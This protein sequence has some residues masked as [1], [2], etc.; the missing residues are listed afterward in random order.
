MVDRVAELVSEGQAATNQIVRLEMLVGCLDEREF[1]RNER[2]FATLAELPIR[3]STWDNAAKLGFLLRRKGITA[4]IP[5]LM[6]ATSAIE[7][8]M[9]LIHADKDFNAMVPFCELRVESYADAAI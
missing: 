1:S 3:Q 7:F 6:I 9:V 8:D 2:D 5:D 4:S